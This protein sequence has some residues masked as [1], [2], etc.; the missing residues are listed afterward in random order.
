MNSYIPYMGRFYFSKL[1]DSHLLRWL[2]WQNVQR[3]RRRRKV[4]TKLFVT[5]CALGSHHQ[6]D[7]EGVAQCTRAQCTAHSAHLHSAQKRTRAQCTRGQEHSAQCTRGPGGGWHNQPAVKVWENVTDIWPHGH[8]DTSCVWCHFIMFTRQ[9][10]K[11]CQ[12]YYTYLTRAR[13]SGLLSNFKNC[14]PSGHEIMQTF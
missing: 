9:I 7:R 1:D 3:A 5:F 6:E 13:V 11:H 10:S 12:K 4:V 14:R 8:L 2:R